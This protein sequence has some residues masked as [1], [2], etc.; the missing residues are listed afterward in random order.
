MS[1]RQ[2]QPR[3]KPS[4][5]CPTLDGDVTPS[6]IAASLARL[7]FSE[8]LQVIKID[9]PTGDY[10]LDCVRGALMSVLG[11]KNGSKDRRTRPAPS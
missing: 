8:S 10:I 6:D 5:P 1:A 11:S 4:G 3:F 9:R 7:K 2:T